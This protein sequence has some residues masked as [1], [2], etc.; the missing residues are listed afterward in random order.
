MDFQKQ[1]FDEFEK[2]HK[3][4]TQVLD[5]LDRVEARLDKIDARIDNLVKLNNLKE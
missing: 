5:R 1:V 2:N 3:F 4:Q